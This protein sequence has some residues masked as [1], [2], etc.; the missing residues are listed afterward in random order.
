MRNR[1]EKMVA[2]AV[3]RLKSV[4][5]Y[6][7]SIKEFEKSGHVMINEPPF[8]AHYFAHDN[9]ELQE[10][11][12]NLEADGN[13][14]YAVVHSFTDFGEMDSILFVSKYEEEWNHDRKD[15]ENG[16][17]FTCTVNWDIPWC[18][19]FGSIGF[20]KTLAGGLMRTC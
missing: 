4:D 7:E 14:V 20:K 10:K 3:K 17:A 9:K 5:Y 19:E 15:L 1:N 8:G 12:D 2:E 11:I 16:I 18:S 13:L 6:D